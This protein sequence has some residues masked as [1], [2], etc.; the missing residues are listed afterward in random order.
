MT[1]S[2]NYSRILLEEVLQC[3]ESLLFMYS[4]CLAMINSANMICF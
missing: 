3:G 4:T 1:H 2:L